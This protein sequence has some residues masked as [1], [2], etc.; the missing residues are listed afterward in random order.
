[1]VSTSSAAGHSSGSTMP[2]EGVC[3][4]TTATGGCKA[5]KQIN[6]NKKS[7]GDSPPTYSLAQQQQ[8]PHQNFNDQHQIHL[9]SS[10]SGGS[11]SNLHN[12]ASAAIN[13]HHHPIVDLYHQQQVSS[14]THSFLAYYALVLI[15]L[16][17]LFSCQDKTRLEW[18][19]TLESKCFTTATLFKTSF[20]SFLFSPSHKFNLNHCLDWVPTTRRQP[21]S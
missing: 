11:P 21:P 12:S 5:T 14:F 15:S 16:L 17:V 8:Q 1:M 13:T 3:T 7:V 19:P 20:F 9:V 18:Q 10:R 4:V 6:R 2:G